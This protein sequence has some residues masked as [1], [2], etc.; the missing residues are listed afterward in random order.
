MGQAGEHCSRCLIRLGFYVELIFPNPARSA[1][2]FAIEGDAIGIGDDLLQR[3]CLNGE[4]VGA[5]VHA[6]EGIIV[7]AGS[8]AGYGKG[9]QGARG[10]QNLRVH[11]SD[12]Y[13][14]ERR[15][16]QEEQFLRAQFKKVHMVTY[17][18]FYYRN[19]RLVDKFQAI[20][21]SQRSGR[22]LVEADAYRFSSS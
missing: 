22:D 7:W 11:R 1:F 2:E 5:K 3:H 21:V 8:D 13:Y 12:A 16:S 20:F 10:V 4:A 17:V 19:S 6:S 18:V 9:G 14:A 15:H